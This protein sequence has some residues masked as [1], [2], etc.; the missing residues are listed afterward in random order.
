MAGIREVAKKAGVSPATVSRTF[1]SPSLINEQTQKRVLEAARLLNYRPPHLRTVKNPRSTAEASSATG[2]TTG[3]ATI[4]FQFFA[5]A[6]EDNLTSNRFYAPVLAGALA[7]ADA[8]GLHLLVH[9]TDRHS[10]GVEMPRMIREKAIRGLLLVGTTDSAIVD[11][12]A[13]N[14]PHMVLVDHCDP[15]GRFDSVVSDGLEGGRRATEYLLRLG[16]RRIAFS[17]PDRNVYSFEERLY[18]YLAAHFEAGI[19]VDPALVLQGSSGE[20]TEEAALTPLLTGENHPTAIF[21]ANDE[22]ALV[23][24]RVCRQRGLK[25]PADISLVGFDDTPFSRST[26][27]ALTTVRVD[28]ERMGRIAVQ[29]LLARLQAP[30]DGEPPVVQSRLPVSL[31]E[32]ESCRPPATTP[33]P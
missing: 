7:E 4:G 31:T 8:Q 12:L 10:L 16:H 29:R 27:P 18:G 19:A 5:R 25:V 11:R 30:P 13:E 24:L 14:I 20:G 26:E 6:A 2:S 1:T 15:R 28:T 9:T 21:C 23:A 17:A 33:K 3:S 32:R 22:H